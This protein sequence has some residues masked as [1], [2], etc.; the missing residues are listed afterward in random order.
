L[1]IFSALGSHTNP[2][3]W[4]VGDDAQGFVEWNDSLAEWADRRPTLL[5]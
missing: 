3:D 4:F 2:E 5:P 1:H